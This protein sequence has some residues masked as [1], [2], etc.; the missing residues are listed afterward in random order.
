MK[1]KKRASIVRARRPGPGKSEDASPAIAEYRN[2]EPVLSLRCHL[3]LAAIEIKA[4]SGLRDGAFFIFL[5]CRPGDITY[6]VA[7]FAR[8]LQYRAT[9]IEI[10]EQAGEKYDILPQSHD[11]ERQTESNLHGGNLSVNS[12]YGSKSWICIPAADDQA[13]YIALAFKEHEWPE[14]FGPISLADV[15][16]TRKVEALGKLVIQDED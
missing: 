14:E 6:L 3:G 4:G 12:H 13:G 7:I 15:N 11:W 2:G 9:L 10:F 5:Q 8:L 1:E 16:M